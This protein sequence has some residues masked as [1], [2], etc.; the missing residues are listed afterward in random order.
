[1][2]KLVSDTI[3]KQDIQ[4]L[5]EWL[6]QDS[7]PQLTKGSLTREL[8]KKWADKIGTKYS[9][10][11]NS[12]SSA[13]LLTLSALKQSGR[14]KNNKV[15]VSSL[16]WH[17]DVSSPMLLGMQT[18]LTDC[19]LK[20]LS[21]DLEH[22]EKIF[23]QQKPSVLILV[24]VLGLVPD[25]QKVLDLCKKYDVILLEDVCESAGSSYKNTKLGN[26]GLAS[27]FSFYYGHHLSTIEGGFI[28]TN[29]RELAALLLSIRNH[30]WDRDL[31][32]EEKQ[33]LRNEWKVDE[34]E[35]LYKFYYQGFNCRSTD[36]QAFIGLRQIDRLDEFTKKR[37]QNFHI[38]K[39]NINCNIL[40]LETEES[41]IVSNFAFP[42]VNEN[43]NNI[44]DKL[45]Q[46]NIEVRPLIA[47]SI[48]NQPFWIKENGETK[49]TNCDIVDKYGFYVPN[50]QALEVKHI[51]QICD[52]INKYGV[53]K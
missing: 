29:D 42:V 5:C 21:C 30:G 52:I 12:G 25:M 39:S 38:Y 1:M 49:L 28:N 45:K 7:T 18:I 36:L 4:D 24:S 16:S 34:F 27:F 17:T 22:L 47:G 46:S 23:I 35:S 33:K 8:E 14:L 44:V 32:E 41:D 20:D 19:N 2:I 10:F 50:N 26:F 13:I 48:A 40:D 6:Q 31:E 43:R 53:K 37:M 11:V 3:S 15:V 9:V 51:M